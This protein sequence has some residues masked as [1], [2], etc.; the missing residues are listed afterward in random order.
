MRAPK[1]I[2]CKVCEKPMLK[3]CFWCKQN[4]APRQS[5]RSHSQKKK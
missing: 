1:K 4:N 3:I 5:L 2:P